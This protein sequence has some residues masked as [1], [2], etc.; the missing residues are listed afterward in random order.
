V[1]DPGMFA[2]EI[3]EKLLLDNV[4]DK[5]NVPSVSSI[6]RI[7]RNKIGPLSQPNN[8]SSASGSGGGGSSEHSDS[9]SPPS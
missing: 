2:W 4:C 1:K 6:S 9:N 5:F 8:G 7:L 3:R